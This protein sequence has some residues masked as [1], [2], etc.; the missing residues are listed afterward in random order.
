MA[1]NVLG[2]TLQPC[3]MD[4]ITGFTRSG[5]CETGPE[6]I[7]SHT[8]CAMMTEEFLAFSLSR[9]NDLSTPQ[10]EYGFPGLAPGER[11]CLC[12]SRWHEAAEAG[13]APPVVLE[14]SHERALEIVSLADLEYHALR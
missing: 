14:A 2:T 5:S 4:P 3:N 8:V 7:G 13:Y 12:A 11:W 1:R 10:P 6:D 9:G